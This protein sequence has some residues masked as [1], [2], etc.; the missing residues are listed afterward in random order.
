MYL[1][2]CLSFITV[3]GSKENQQRGEEYGTDA[4]ENQV[5]D[6]KIDQPGALPGVLNSST[7]KFQHHM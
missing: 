5:Q 7:V 6:S 1:C 4:V 2:L 3:K